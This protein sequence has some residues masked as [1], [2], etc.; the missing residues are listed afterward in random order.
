MPDL[1]YHISDRGDITQFVPRP[2]PVQRP[3]QAAPEGEMV[4]AIDGD[5]LHNYLLPRDCP[6]ITYYALPTST[7]E[8]VE[9]LMAGTG[10]R[11]VVAIETKWLP[12]LQR[13]TLYRYDFA[14]DPFVAHDPGAGYYIACEPI[15][16]VAV[17]P[18]S[19][20]IAELLQHNVEL[21]IMPSLWGLCDRVVASSLQFSCIRMRNATP[22]PL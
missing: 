11:Y 6:R 4:W 21:R 9:R 17:T 20:L 12:E 10:A 22:R 3:G 15:T 13:S 8:D 7:S 2:A 16:P 1:L 5:H 19:D 14:P 18:I